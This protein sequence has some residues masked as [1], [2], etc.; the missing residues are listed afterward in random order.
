MQA[1]SLEIKKMNLLA[2]FCIPIIVFF[3]F[4]IYLITCWYLFPY[5]VQTVP[6][7]DFEFYFPIMFTLLELNGEFTKN[8]TASLHQIFYG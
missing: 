8:P 3:V 2:L 6:V 1:N 5:A 4:W 7:G